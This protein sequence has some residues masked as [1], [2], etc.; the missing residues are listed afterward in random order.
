MTGDITAGDPDGGGFHFCESLKDMGLWLPSTFSTCH[1]GHNFT[2]THPGSHASRIDFFAVSGGF[3][4]ENLCTWVDEDIDLLNYNEDH[5]PVRMNAACVIVAEGPDVEHVRI[6]RYD[7]A[8]LKDPAVRGK[9]QAGLQ[10]LTI[11]DWDV[12][13]NAHADTFQTQIQMVLDELIPFDPSRPKSAYIPDEA[14][15]L[16]RAKQKLKSRTANRKKDHRSTL[17]GLLFDI[18]AGDGARATVAQRLLRKAVVLYEVVAGAIHFATWRMRRL[19][20]QHKKQMLNHLSESCGKCD[21][22]VIM[23]RLRQLQLGRRR[24]K[25]WR[26]HLP[27][28]MRE[29]GSMTQDRADLDELWMRFFSSMEAGQVMDVSDFL[30]EAAAPRS[31]HEVELDLRAVPSLSALECYL[32]GTKPRKAPGL[33]AIPGEVLKLCAQPMARLLHPLI[34]KSALHIRQP[35]QWR[36]GTLHAAFKGAGLT[37]QPSN[38]RSLFVSS[39]VGKTYHKL[40]REQIAPWADSS[41]GSCQFGAK[42]GSPVVHG[43]HIVV[44]HEQ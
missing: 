32:R 44:P 37:S 30:T 3:A 28:M 39:S 40:I 27:G 9:L 21:P 16:R 1:T 25:R 7:L 15:N 43:S 11:P 12:D 23:G 13:V 10:R 38:Y 19:I 18:W 4:C 8:K 14:W 31:S 42:K 5:K 26:R 24:P 33:D 2:Y 17:S 35:V 41:F 36:G 34:L 22:N 20:Q 29:D 6:K